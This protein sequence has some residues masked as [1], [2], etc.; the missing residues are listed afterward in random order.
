L[1]GGARVNHQIKAL[2]AER[3]LNGLAGFHIQLRRGQRPRAAR[4]IQPPFRA[5]PSST[6]RL[7]PSFPFATM[8]LSMSATGNQFSL[9]RAASTKGPGAQTQFPERQGEVLLLRG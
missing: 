4:Q 9:T 7:K 3:T 1:A 6:C 5:A 2:A 8:R